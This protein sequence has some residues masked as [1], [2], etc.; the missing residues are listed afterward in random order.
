VCPDGAAARRSRPDGD[1]DG[2]RRSSSSPVRRLVKFV[3]NVHA[4]GGRDRCSVVLKAD[5]VIAGQ[6]A[7][8]HQPLV[9]AADAG[10]CPEVSTRLKAA[11]VTRDGLRSPSASR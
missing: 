6:R 4:T 8:H 7:G 11:P 2:K 5:T 3:P 10:A 1:P 9:G